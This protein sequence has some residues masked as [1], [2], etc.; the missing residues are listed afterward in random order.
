MTDHELI[1]RKLL[2]AAAR[3]GKIPVHEWY[4]SGASILPIEG[5]PGKSWWN[6]LTD[7]GDA[8]RLAVTLKMGVDITGNAAWAMVENDLH[9]GY[10]AAIGSDS[11][12]AARRA[13]VRAA[14]AMA[15]S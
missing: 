13:I 7:D 6:P 5:W 1:D 12:A 8:F 15:A 11:F 14:A 3:A 2:E 4:V 9:A 10:L